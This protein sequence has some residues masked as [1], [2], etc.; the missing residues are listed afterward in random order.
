MATN[1]AT[2]YVQVVPSTEGITAGLK[3]AFSDGSADTAGT[4]WGGAFI[5]KLKGV[6]A[7][8]GIGDAIR[9]S[10]SEGADLQQS[11]GGI[12]TLFGKSADKVI[13]N[14]NRAFE[15]S[16][17]SA[18]DYMETVTSFSASLLQSLDGDTEAA[19]AAADQALIDMSDNANKMGTD[20]Q[21]IQNAYSGFA[22]GN[23]TMLDNLKLGYAGNADE[24]QRLLDKAEELSGQ[25]FDISSY[26]DI[27]EAIHIIQTEMGITGTTA[28]EAATTFS[29]SMASMKAA[30]S[31]VLG[32]L[33]TGGDMESAIQSLVSTAGTF[34][35]NNLIPMITNIVTGVAQGLPVLLVAFTSPENI[36]AL[37][38]CALQ[39]VTTMADGLI[40]AVPALIAAA[41]QII[42]GIIVGI[43]ASLGDI[44]SS[45]VEII[46]SL[47]VGLID[48]IP[49]L[50]AAIPDL[51][52]GIVG[53]IASN[54]DKIILAAPQ[55]IVALATGMVQSIGS[56]INV[57][58]EIISSIVDTFRAFDWGSI[59]ANIV[60]GIANGFQ[61][62]WQSLVATV[63]QMVDNLVG[64]VKNILGIHSPSKVFAGIGGFM[65]EGLGEGFAD[66]M[67]SVNDEMD[68]AI[69]TDFA[70]TGS[71]LMSGSALG[72]SAAA[73]DSAVI[74]ELESIK[75]ILASL[76]FTVNLDGKK[77][78]DTIN[79]YQRQALRAVGG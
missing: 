52:I 14:A 72:A 3:K 64:T 53:G 19:A 55:I 51:I 46:N 21:M 12:E 45:G 63:Q 76:D 35:Y 47:V 22:R 2:A 77:V 75:A 34:L 20:M 15:T 7:A 49:Q 60:N 24:M 36:Q 41:P 25:H 44:I 18:N 74:K 40:Q 6:I 26:A 67:E 59:G 71:A 73:S 43:I 54:L 29:G 39:M 23:F 65:A 5:S 8:A 62:L 1:L 57:I 9:R 27:T 4:S 70:V 48:S 16:G 10:I 33:A 30:L 37:V 32:T 56:L 17:L 11:L 28:E 13:A 42:S 58:P 31:N 78:S 66:G 79:K 69:Q 61:Q 68:N 38:D 50:V